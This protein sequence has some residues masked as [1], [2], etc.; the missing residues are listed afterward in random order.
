[1]ARPRA[2]RGL[3]GVRVLRE[4][5]RVQGRQ[6]TGAM[7]VVFTSTLNLPREANAN[8]DAAPATALGGLPFG[9][10][11]YSISQTPQVWLDH[12][13]GEVGGALTFN[14]DVVEELFPPA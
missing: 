9:Q 10:M 14:W 3:S 8:A 4:L 2:P 1:M 12:Q 7:P 5:A 11:V 6:G 13:V